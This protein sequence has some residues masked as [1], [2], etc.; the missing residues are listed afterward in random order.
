MGYDAMSF[1]NGVEAIGGQVFDDL[2]CARGPGDLYRI[3]FGGGSEPK[4]QAE[5]VLGDIAS[6]AQN[7]T[8]LREAS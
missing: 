6:S 4:V 8:D 1:Q 3:C 7:F 5:I 2:F